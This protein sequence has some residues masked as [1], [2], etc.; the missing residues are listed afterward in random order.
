MEPRQIVLTDSDQRTWLESFQADAAGSSIR[1]GTIRGG[2]GDGI[3]VVDLDNGLFS[4]SLLPTRGMS[5]WRARCGDL[6]L[7]WDSP[8]ARP[9]H[10]SLINAA[11]DGG[12]GWLAGFN[13][14]LV[15]CGLAWHGPPGLDHVPDGKGGFA[16][17]PVTL[18]GRIANIPAHRVE[19][20][21]DP[22]GTGEISVT[23]E[24]EETM[25]FGPRFQL[26]STLSTRPGSAHL[27][28]RDRI[29]N[30]GA[31]PAEFE[32][33]YHTNLGSPLLQDGS[34]LVAP[35]QRVIPR[36][37]HAADD[38]ATYDQFTG[39]KIDYAEQCY[40]LELNGDSDM[41]SE[42]LLHNA[43]ADRGLSLAFSLES[44]PCFTLWKNTQAEAD[45]YVVGIEPS[46][47]YPN[48][49]E[50]ERQ[51]GRVRQLEPG[52]SWESQLTLLA[53]LSESD[54]AAGRQRIEVL[55]GET[56]P[57]LCVSPLDGSCPDDR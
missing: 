33:L 16:N 17:V 37:N 28:I 36:N 49:R 54:V 45:G 8:V 23:G 10:P 38:V 7:G 51:Q 44:L 53:L 56:A 9:V 14:L 5:L 57:Q 25:L 27:T 46:T 4:V 20:T 19:L 11:A 29:T 50:F 39:P 13:E 42:V 21:F 2:P 15:R 41:R 3:D 48:P 26:T 30:L 43:A 40:F 12:L 31:K 55:Q 6:S 18:H 34:R 47:D 1:K 32:L 22:E 52:E 35:A 24:V